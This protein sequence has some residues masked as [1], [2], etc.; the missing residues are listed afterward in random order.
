MHL[1]HKVLTQ[2]DLDK[3]QTC[4]GQHL[5]IRVQY[6]SNFLRWIYQAIWYFD[7]ACSNNSRRIN[8]QHMMTSSNG[9]IFP[10][11]W[12]FVRGIH[13]SPVNSPHKGQWRGPLMLSL[14]CARI[15]D[16]VNK[17]EAGDLRR[18]RAHHD[19]TVMIH[20]PADPLD[21]RLCGDAEWLSLRDPRCT[22]QGVFAHSRLLPICDAFFIQRG[23]R[24]S[25]PFLIGEE[26]D[27]GNRIKRALYI[28]IKRLCFCCP[29]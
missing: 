10:R 9:N 8:W 26:S 3:W 15:N 17:R 12:P 29:Q 18:R 27:D 6:T 22:Q 19:V 24:R 25:L 23:H 28:G 20:S 4:C 1:L 21:S 2:W 13:R 7:S 5:S 11:Y 14:I 16:W